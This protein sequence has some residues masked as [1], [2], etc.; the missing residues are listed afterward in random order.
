MKK[1]LKINLF[2]D[3]Q[4]LFEFFVTTYQQCIWVSHELLDAS[5]KT[6]TGSNKC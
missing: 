3:G 2:Y 5:R 4:L 1:T 6:F